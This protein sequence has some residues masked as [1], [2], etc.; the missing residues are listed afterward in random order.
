MKN[1]HGK[2]VLATSLLEFFWVFIAMLASGVL[3][4]VAGGHDCWRI[5]LDNCLWPQSRDVGKD[6]HQ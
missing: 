6:F 5:G 4:Q 1:A 2:T 3:L